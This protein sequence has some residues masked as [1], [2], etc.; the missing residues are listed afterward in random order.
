MMIERFVGREQFPNFL[1]LLRVVRRWAKK[2]GLYGNKLGYLGG[3]NCNLLAAFICQ[4]YPHASPSKLIH[5]FFHLYG[6][7]WKWP[8]PVKLNH[9][10]ANPPTAARQL[11]IWEPDLSG[12]RHLMPM[13]TPAYP[14]SNSSFNVSVHTREIMLDEMRL[15]SDIVTS[16]LESAEQEWGRLFEPSDFFVRYSHYLCCHIVGTGTDVEST[17]WMGKGRALL[18]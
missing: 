17:S 1:V 7:K 15:A 9:I 4:L 18:L 3:I 12:K 6:T 16:I 2:R 10:K 5:R 11:D 13:V 14:A 8:N